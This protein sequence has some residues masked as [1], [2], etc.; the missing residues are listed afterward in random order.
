MDIKL[1]VNEWVEIGKTAGWIRQAGGFGLLGEDISD[2]LEAIV[3]INQKTK[4]ADEIFSL[5]KM[6]TSLY[7]QIQNSGVDDDL[8]M[9]YIHEMINTNNILRMTK[10]KESIVKEAAIPSETP[11]ASAAPDEIGR[12]QFDALIPESRTNPDETISKD[13]YKD[14]DDKQSR[15]RTI[16]V[17]FSDNDTL[18]TWI[19]GTVD[20]IKRYY[21]PWGDRGIDQDYD[22]ARPHAVRHP[23]KVEFLD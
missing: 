11:A 4:S 15:R 14:W 18:E 2:V 20:E 10:V 7:A 13:E 5:V 9:E 22:L 23:V 21:L 19:N 1:S 8:L 6:D 3:K 12:D 17:T 16:R